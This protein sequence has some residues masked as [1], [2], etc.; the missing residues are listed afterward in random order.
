MS[1]KALRNAVLIAGPTASGKSAM[2]IEVARRIGGVVVNADSMQVYDV[3]RSL[4]ARPAEQ[5]PEGVPHLLYGHA[6]P[7]EPYSVG[8]WLAEVR[9]LARDGA[10]ETS[11]PVFV[12][13][14]GLY[15]EALLGGLSR[16]P[17]IPE[18]VRGYW[19]GR[20]GDEGARALHAELSRRDPL[21]AASLRDADGQRIVRALEVLEATGRSIRDWQGERGEPLVDAA[22]ADRIVLD[23]DRVLLASRVSARLH[24]MIEEGALDE[25]RALLDL[26]I[27][28]LMPAMKAIGVREFS[29]VLAGE[30]TA[31][32]AVERAAAATRR[33]AKRQGTWFRNRFGTEWRRIRV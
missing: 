3:L 5:E 16:M 12:G 6:D 31:Q 22:S 21:T 1:L 24:T 9:A 11:P 25:V 29:A 8:D 17:A 10:F 14:T 30:A 20:L 23:I 18:D 4:T 27:G 26:G 7:R 33:Y 28:P 19:R 2:A 13:G 15:F 32:E